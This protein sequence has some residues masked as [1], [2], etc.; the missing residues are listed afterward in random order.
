[1]KLSVIIPCINAA[2]TIATQLE[3][4]AKQEWSEPWEIIVSNNGSSDGTLSIVE[5]YR[6]RLPN[7]RVVDSSDIRG[8]AHARN[9]GAQAAKGETLAFCD[10][11][12]EVAPGWVAAIGEALMSHDFV[13]SRMDF[14]KLNQGRVLEAFRD[15]PQ[16]YGLQRI[17]YPPHLLHAGGSG[18]G[19]KRSLHETVG[20]FDESLMRLV[21]TDYCFRIQLSGVELHFVQNAIVYVR[22]KDNLRGFFKQACLWAEYNVLMY[23]RYGV[24]GKYE[25]WR[26]KWYIKECENLFRSLS[27]IR[28]KREVGNWI[29]RFS[30]NIGRLKGSIKHRVP[31]V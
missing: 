17:W 13:A 5:Q 16:K 9:V 28:S 20:G 1:M 22:L 4:L 26:W 8:S 25:A 12:D 21:D 31:P 14:D 30:W 19:V 18:L 11:D 29:W 3:A 2:G 27:Q 15:H 7:L 10:A 6:K 23:K 24:S